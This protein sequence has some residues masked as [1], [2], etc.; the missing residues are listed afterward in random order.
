VCQ[1]SSNSSLSP[2]LIRA[3]SDSGAIIFVWSPT[4]HAGHPEFD[5]Y[6]VSI[7][8]IRTPD[9]WQSGFAVIL[10][11]IVKSVPGNTVS[12]SFSN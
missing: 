9:P 6:Q 4:T 10:Q 1:F 8:N 12:V 5:G 7:T 2:S 11:I 3:S